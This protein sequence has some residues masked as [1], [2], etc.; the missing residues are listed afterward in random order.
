M[1]PILI[2]LVAGSWL[3]VAINYVRYLLL[4][5]QARI[6]TRLLGTGCQLL[7]IMFATLYPVCK[8]FATLLPVV[9]QIVMWMLFELISKHRI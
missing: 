2:I 8:N 9:P 5:W 7:A 3:L 1:G 6:A 4:Y